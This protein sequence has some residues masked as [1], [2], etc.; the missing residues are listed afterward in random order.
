MA[1]E[2]REFR[3]ILGLT[4]A[5][6]AG[7]LGVSLRAVEEWEGSR[8]P[9]P[10]YLQLALERLA[11]L[12]TTADRTTRREIEAGR[13]DLTVDEAAGMA[14]WNGLTVKDRAAW[15]KRAGGTGVVA[16]AWAA[17]KASGDAGRERANLP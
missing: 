1:D 2:V 13:V 6:L 14:W 5:G 15:M 4:Q 10:T 12:K 7:A 8:N 11:T 9:V 17:A 3:L 16:D